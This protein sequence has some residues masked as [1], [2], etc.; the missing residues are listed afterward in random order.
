MM[1]TG[2]RHPFMGKYKLKVTKDGYFKAC[3]AD[4]YNNAGH[5]IDLSYS[6]MERAITHMD[7]VYNFPKIKLRGRMAKTNLPSNTA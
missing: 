4:L 5:S 3:E 7:N 2:N 6:V 1:V